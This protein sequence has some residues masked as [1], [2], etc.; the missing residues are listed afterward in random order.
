MVYWLP[1]FYLCLWWSANGEEV[2]RA[3]DTLPSWSWMTWRGQNDLH[4]KVSKD[5]WRKVGCHCVLLNEPGQKC[6]RKVSDDKQHPSNSRA[7]MMSDVPVTVRSKLRAR[8]HILF[9]GAQASILDVQ[10]SGEKP[11]RIRLIRTDEQGCKNWETGYVYREPRPIS[12]HHEIILVKTEPK[13][14]GARGEFFPRQHRLLLIS[15]LDGIAR[16]ERSAEID[17]NE[18]EQSSPQWKLII[19]E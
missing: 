2:P 8:F 11:R 17:V 4:H 5:R 10:K 15:W 9:L 12:G 1:M 14:D 7:I 13:I 3:T 6:L 16:R 19:M 18:W